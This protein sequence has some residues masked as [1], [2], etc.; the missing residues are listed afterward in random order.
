MTAS[1]LHMS[2]DPNTVPR[3]ILSLTYLPF[4]KQGT[5]KYKM[6][7][8]QK[9]FPECKPVSEK[10]SRGAGDFE[11]QLD[12]PVSRP[13]RNLRVQK[14]LTLWVWHLGN[15]VYFVPNGPL[16]RLLVCR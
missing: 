3:D 14:T 7:K 4:K 15:K 8:K 9:H 13:T 1:P 5:D 11:R 16:F 6:I 12:L 2:R 10:V